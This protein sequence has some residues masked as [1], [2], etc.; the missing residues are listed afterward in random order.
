MKNI[1]N[2]KKRKEKMKQKKIS[3]I[4]NKNVVSH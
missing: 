1:S 3:K 2:H 4:K